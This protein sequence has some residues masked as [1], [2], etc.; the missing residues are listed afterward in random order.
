MKPE[1]H[2]VYVQLHQP[3]QTRKLLLESTIHSIELLERFEYL[4][5]TRNL[6]KDRIRQ[7]KSVIQEIELELHELTRSLPQ[8]TIKNHEKRMINV[9]RE[10]ES[11]KPLPLET[12]KK[13]A[14]SE[15]KRLENEL[16]E[17]KSKLTS[18][19]L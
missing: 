15:L 5:E 7:A 10:E 6:K 13:R 12:S 16:F 1:T 11:Q 14:N 17:I 2:P 8:I 3:V 4:K 19:N 9:A 18:M